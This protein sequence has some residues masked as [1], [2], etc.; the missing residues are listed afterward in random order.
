MEKELILE[1]MNLMTRANSENDNE[2]TARLI[3]DT[4][5]D[6]TYS[7][8]S[9][10]FANVWNVVRP[11]INL[12][13]I[14]I[15]TR[16]A[17]TAPAST[18]VEGIIIEDIIKVFLLKNA[19]GIPENVGRADVA[20]MNK[21]NI[22]QYVEVKSKIYYGDN[23]GVFVPE[24]DFSGIRFNNENKSISCAYSLIV[25]EFV[26]SRSNRRFN[27][28]H[29]I[30]LWGRVIDQKARTITTVINPQN[31]EFVLDCEGQFLDTSKTGSGR[32][33]MPSSYRHRFGKLN[34]VYLFQYRDGKPTKLKGTPIL[35]ADGGT[36]I[37]TNKT[38]VSF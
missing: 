5:F 10:Y 27:K 2:K 16:K 8:I 24:T 36:L 22:A 38:I 12:N 15:F 11:Q 13:K 32:E 14:S 35:N 25:V 21:N 19:E 9:F 3:L 7:D 34:T 1:N 33:Y 18:A 23:N 31:L 29:V 37:N 28:V 6:K 26:G 30:K 4:A 20:Y 17:T